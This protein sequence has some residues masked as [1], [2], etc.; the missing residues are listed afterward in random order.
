[1]ETSFIALS[2]E[3]EKRVA[4][5]LGSFQGNLPASQSDIARAEQYYD[6]ALPEDLK[7]LYQRYNGTMGTVFPQCGFMQPLPENSEE[8]FSS[9]HYSYGAPFGVRD[10][11]PVFQCDP[12]VFTVVLDPAYVGQVWIY[13]VTEDSK[14]IV[15]VTSNLRTLFA[16]WIRLFDIGVFKK[17]QDDCF[18]AG[19]SFFESFEAVWPYWPDINPLVAGSSVPN[20]YVK[21]FL[22]P[23]QE[24][25]DVHPT[26]IDKNIDSCY[27][28]LDAMEERDSLIRKLANH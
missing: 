14:D 6:R 13:D 12:F 1:M 8:A 24:K 7:L 11:I 25:S 3:Y 2:E 18:G 15:C 5:V 19:D 28:M 26:L 9:S 16:D 22:I 17:F 20:K 10:H 23:L 27:L 21:T 4:A